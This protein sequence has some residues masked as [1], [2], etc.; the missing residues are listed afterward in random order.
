MAVLAGRFQRHF[1][2]VLRNDPGLALF[3]FADRRTEK[4]DPALPPFGRALGSVLRSGGFLPF[5]AY[6]FLLALF[7][8]GCPTLFGLVEK[9]FL[10][11]SDGTV[12][13]LANARL[14]GSILGFYLGGKIVE[15]FG[16]K[17][18]FL[19][20]HFCFGLILFA[21]LWRDAG[22]DRSSPSSAA[23]SFSSAW[24]WPPR[25]SRS[26]SRCTR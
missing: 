15:R 13:L 10:H 18:V 1:R 25:R 2:R 6:A 4:P 9:T 17:P 22:A 3:L 11:L 20:C 16:T 21:F 26:R 5:C 8:G 12:T 7:T 23:W 24:R 19:S 14:V